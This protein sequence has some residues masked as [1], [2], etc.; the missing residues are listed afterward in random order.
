M[1][2]YNY[3][4]TWRTKDNG[5]EHVVPRGTGNY[6]AKLKGQLNTPPRDVALLAEI[7]GEVVGEVVRE[8]I[9]EGLESI[10]NSL[11]PIDRE[12]AQFVKIVILARSFQLEC[13]EDELKERKREEFKMRKRNVRREVKELRAVKKK[14]GTRVSYPAAGLVVF[15]LV[16]LAW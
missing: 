13:I 5:K 15:V 2:G 9:H 16:G 14:L 8:V 10:Q 11:H 6:L 4:V 7:I 3:S 12:L 1:S